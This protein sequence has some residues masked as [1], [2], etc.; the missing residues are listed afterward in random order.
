MAGVAGFFFCLPVPCFLP[1]GRGTWGVLG[2]ETDD[3]E[4]GFMSRDGEDILREVET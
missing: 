4:D 2:V 3:V 1:G